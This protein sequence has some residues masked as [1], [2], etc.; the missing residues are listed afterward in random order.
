MLTDKEAITSFARS[1]EDLLKKVENSPNLRHSQLADTLRETIAFFRNNSYNDLK[2]TEWL[3]ELDIYSSLLIG[4]LEQLSEAKLRGEIIASR[5]RLLKEIR[6]SL[7]PFIHSH[8]DLENQDE[9]YASKKELEILAG[10]ARELIRQMSSRLS[11]VDRIKQTTSEIIGRSDAD[12]KAL[13]HR[14]DEI[15]IA[16]EEK[17]AKV[18][19]LLDITID[20]TIDKEKQINKVLGHVSGRVISGDF[21][22]NASEERDIANILRYGS[23]FCMVLIIGIAG[24][25]FLETTTSDFDWTEQLSRFV[26]MILLSIPAAYLARE[27]EKHRQQQYSH[28][29]K[30]LDL[31]TATPFLSSLPEDEQHKLK[32]QIAAKLFLTNNISDTKDSFPINTHE[33]LM[34]LLSKID[35]QR[36]DQPESHAKKS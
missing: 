6:L 15:E 29:Q 3:Q 11:E 32:M 24:Y 5:S 35:I 8:F 21:E 7:K 18:E 19:R 25:S 13:A 30:S 12:I 9:G 1:V 34:E 28:L 27:S 22:K 20:S 23:I 31:N 33:L 14:I 10:R 4:H 26:L 2:H 36:S 17:L 16:A